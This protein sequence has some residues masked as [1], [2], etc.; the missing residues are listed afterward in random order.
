MKQ[1]YL[2]YLHDGNKV[3]LL[4]IHKIIA[5]LYSFLIQQ[6]LEQK[7]YKYFVL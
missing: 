1:L 6:G 4:N 7:H 2:I 3:C 5:C